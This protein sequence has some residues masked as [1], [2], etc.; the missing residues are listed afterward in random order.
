[1]SY[2]FFGKVTTLGRGC[3]FWV[4]IAISVLSYPRKIVCVLP[5]SEIFCVA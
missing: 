2:S 4:I 5:F 3:V 1:M